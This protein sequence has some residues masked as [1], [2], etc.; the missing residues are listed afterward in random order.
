MPWIISQ[1]LMDVYENSRCLQEQVEGY[2]EGICLGGERSVPSSGIHT[3]QL[4]LSPGKM[5]EFSRLSRSGITCKPLTDA[6]GEDLLMW[7]LAVFLAKTYPRPEKGLESKANEAG[8]GRKWLGLFAKFDLNSCSWKTLQCSLLEG[9]DDYSEIWPRWGT[10]RNGECWERTM[11]E[12]LT[13]ETEFGLSQHWPTPICH[14]A[15]ESDC[16]SEATRNEPSLT[17]QARGGDETLPKKLNPEWV[18]WLMGWP[19]G[20]TNLEPLGM[21][22]FQQWQSSHGV[23]C[24]NEPSTIPQG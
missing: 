6:L 13:G 16:P 21:D 24:Q 11:P 4:Y 5:K 8:C 1:K 9:L 17:H 14:M 15:K 23:S 20:W 7:Y 18:E 22:R 10:M 3:V 2:S 12:R 19:I